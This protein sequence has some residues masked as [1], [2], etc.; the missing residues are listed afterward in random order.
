MHY[1]VV[2]FHQQIECMEL[3]PTTSVVIDKPFLHRTGH[4][5][6]LPER[7]GLASSDQP[8]DC[9]ESQTVLHI[10]NGWQVNGIYSALLKQWQCMGCALKLV[11]TDLCTFKAIFAFLKLFSRSSGTVRSICRNMD[12]TFRIVD[13]EEFIT[14]ISKLIAAVWV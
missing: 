14:V 13:L 11:P 9:S 1:S 3:Y 6:V 2:I 10:V 5:Q 12:V 8:R 7:W 4:L